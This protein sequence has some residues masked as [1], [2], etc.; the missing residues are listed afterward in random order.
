VSVTV[1][2]PRRHSFLFQHDFSKF[3]NICRLDRPTLPRLQRVWQ[4]PLQAFVQ[5]GGWHAPRLPDGIVLSN[6]SA[7]RQHQRTFDAVHADL[8]EL[9]EVHVEAITFSER[10]QIDVDA[11]VFDPNAFG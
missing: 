5:K 11:I 6:S 3:C 9:I 7:N 2:T 8:V 4:P 1:L 10:A